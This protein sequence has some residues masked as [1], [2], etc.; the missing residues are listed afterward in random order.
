MSFCFRVYL[1]VLQYVKMNMKTKKPINV[2]D[3]FFINI[4]NYSIDNQI[5]K[6]YF[7]K[8]KNI[9]RKIIC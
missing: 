2:T 4:K 9:F 6:N 8:L 7:R 3:F 1:I 5:H